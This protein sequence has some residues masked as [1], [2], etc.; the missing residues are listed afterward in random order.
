MEFRFVATA[1]GIGL[2]EDG[3]APIVFVMGG[4]WPLRVELSNDRKHG[5]AALRCEATAEFEPK[6]RIVE[7]FVSLAT[8]Q[9]PTGSTPAEQWSKPLTQL[10]PSGEIRGRLQSV[11]MDYMP[12]AFKDFAREIGELLSHAG[13]RAVDLLRW[14]SGELG[15]QRPFSAQ[16]TEWR[17]EEGSY[18]HSFP[19]GTG[20]TIDHVAY[21]E[22]RPG[23]HDDLQRL[24]DEGREEPFAYELLREAWALRDVSPR[25]SLLLSITA[26][27]VAVKQYVADRVP[28]AEWLVNNAPS[29]DVVKLLREYLPTLEPSAS[30]PINAEKLRKLP[31]EL[32]D[33]LRCLRDQ[34]NGVAHRPESHLKPSLRITPKRAT[35]AVLAVRQV[36]MRLD[37]ASGEAWAEEHVGSWAHV[38]SSGWRRVG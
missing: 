13:R 10:D 19:G 1:N 33:V 15:A 35:S 11:P 32:L 12:P 22:V 6:A 20:L 2:H 25:T 31:Q 27:E 3:V 23:A 17:L 28:Q 29:P 26:L 8:S 36:L 34:R 24:F 7:A 37:V 14:R 16:S 21:P 30:A 9:M 38:P 4:N 5:G 18:W